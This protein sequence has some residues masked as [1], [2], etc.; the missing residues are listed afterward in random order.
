MSRLFRRGAPR[1]LLLLALAAPSCS[2][3]PGG[4]DTY[5]LTAQFPT[6]VA[7]YPHGDV[8]VMGFDVGTVT[9]VSLEDT[10]VRVEMDIRS[11]VPLPADVQAAI[12]PT[13]LIG[14]RVIQLFPPWDDRMARDNRPRAGD[15]DVIPMSRTIVPVEPDEGLEAFN[16]VAQSLDP[17]VV[18]QA[19]SSAADVLEGRGEELNDALRRIGSLSATVAGMD[20]QLVGAAEAVHTFTA[21]LNAREEQIGTLVENFG[22]VADMLAA[23]RESIASILESVVTLTDQGR[24][25][26]DLFGDTLP[27][28]L[29]SVADTADVLAANASSLDQLFR[30]FGIM[31]QAL[32]TFLDPDTGAIRLSVNLTPTVVSVLQTFLEGGGLD[33]AAVAA[34]FEQ[35]PSSPIGTTCPP[36]G[37]PPP[38]G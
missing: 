2:L 18:G 23:E 16:D 1:V 15:G 10:F 37:V 9:E 14:E 30:S 19:V 11:D 8:M 5:S 25:L 34:L 12:D 20:E 27:A 4:G 33:P 29:A 31:T 38:C 6:A 3:L 22:A 7:L 21:S 24:Q 13:N 36:E 32:A 26:L 17:A 35:I 28:T